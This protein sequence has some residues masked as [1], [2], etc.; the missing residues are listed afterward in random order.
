MLNFTN[1]ISPCSAEGQGPT[2]ILTQPVD[3]TAYVGESVTFSVSA[4]N[5]CLFQ[6]RHD[7]TNVTG[8]RSPGLRLNNVQPWQAGE[9]RAFITHASGTGGAFSQ[10]ARLTVLSRPAQLSSARYNNGAFAFHVA[11]DTGRAVVIETAPNLNPG[12][13][14]TPVFT[15]AAPFSFTNSTPAERQR[16]Y[17]T[18]VQ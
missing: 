5:H 4:T 8:A 9:Y 15:N 7:G 11:V 18:V 3:Q 1:F 14:W 6:W 10:I 16:F 2:I 13:T 12:T 17:R